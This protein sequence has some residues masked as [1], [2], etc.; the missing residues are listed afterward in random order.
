MDKKQILDLRR[1]ALAYA[2]HKKYTYLA[3]DFA[4]YFLLWCV[5]NPDYTDTPHIRLRFID[6][7]RQ[8]YGETNRRTGEPSRN[9]ELYYEKELR[10]DNKPDNTNLNPLHLAQVKQIFR[11][12]DP[13]DR[14]LLSLAYYYCFETTEIAE[15]MAVTPGRVS[16]MLSK[17]YKKIRAF[18]A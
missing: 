13:Y 6:F 12:L 4:Q 5:K 10:F 9:N 18:E 17:V 15:M 7:L 16:Q 2:R 11:Q 14:L 3:E 8:T 1:K